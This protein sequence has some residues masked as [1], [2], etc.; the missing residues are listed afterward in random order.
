MCVCVREREREN[1]YIREWAEKWVDR[2][3]HMMTTYLMMMTVFINGIQAL[4]HRRKE[5]V[6]RK[7]DDVKK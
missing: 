6:I 4:Q 7:G 2:K 1:K 5:C 3:I